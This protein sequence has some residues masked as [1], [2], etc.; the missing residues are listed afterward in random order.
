MKSVI[1]YSITL[2]SIALMVT[3][4]LKVPEYPDTPSIEFDNVYFKQGDNQNVFD[5]LFVSIKFKDGDGDLGL[6]DAFSTDPYNA[7]W[8]FLK[9]GTPVDINSGFN[10][11]RPAD[12]FITL[13]DRN[14]P[15]Y[16]TLPTYEFPY[17]CYNYLIDTL[18]NNDVDTFYV[19][20]NLDHYN[21]FV[22]FYVRKNGQ[23]YYYDWLTEFAPQ[24][25]ESYYGR[26]P[27]LNRDENDNTSLKERPLEGTLAYRIVGVRILDIFKND[28]LKLEIKIKD[29]ALNE[30]N[31]VETFEFVLKDITIN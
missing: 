28:T 2:F 15:P 7:T 17:F 9:N 26:F 8:Y 23:Y 14:T 10:S 30:S 27:V 1:Q 12:D 11:G 19:H 24:C 22:D 25:G 18:D 3:S 21:I 20:P 16:D 4:C 6:N 31:T 5:S 13:S 29:R